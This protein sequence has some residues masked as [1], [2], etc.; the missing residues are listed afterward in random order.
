LKNGA[1][2]VGPIKDISKSGTSFEYICEND[3]GQELRQNLDIFIFGNAFKLPDIVCE[4][5]YDYPLTKS[6]DKDPSL[7]WNVSRRC[8]VQFI[9]LDKD[10]REQLLYFIANYNEGLAL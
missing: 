4:V 1:A 2:E 6:N 9:R 10:Q 3:V 5:V 7:T 8:G